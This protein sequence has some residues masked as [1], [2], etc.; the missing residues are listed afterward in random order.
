MS[1]VRLISQTTGAGEFAGKGMEDIVVYTARVSSNREDKFEEPEGLLR[2]CINGAH[3]SIFEVCS[4]TVEIET[5]VVVSRQILRHRSF[6]FQEF[7]QR[8]SKVSGFE[9]IELRKQATKNRQSSTDAFDPEIY[10]HN[11]SI[12][13]SELVNRTLHGIYEAYELLLKEGV[14]K[15]SARSILP[16]ASTTKLFMT[17]NLRSWITYFNVRCSE[18]TQK[19]HRE[20]ANAIKAIFKENL[21]IISKALNY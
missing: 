2:Y 7:S 6:T 9:P 16:L 1:K 21:P 5:S 12:P 19:E 14:A 10:L 4:F 13:A 15:E 17:G 8:Y 18:H 3:W 20:V 11:G